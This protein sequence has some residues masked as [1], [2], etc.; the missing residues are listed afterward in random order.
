MY[1]LQHVELQVPSPKQDEV[2]LKMEATSINPFDLRIQKGIVWPFLPRKFPH[3]PGTYHLSLHLQTLHFSSMPNI[4]NA[5][6]RSSAKEFFVGAGIDAAGE[7]FEV[8]SGVKNFKAGDK[9]VAVLFVS[10]HSYS[11]GLCYSDLSASICYMFDNMYQT[12]VS[13]TNTSCRVAW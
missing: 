7:V 2:L 11:S 5:Y 9:V 6:F 8:G 1:L 3:I 12:R 10:C 13:D 4:S